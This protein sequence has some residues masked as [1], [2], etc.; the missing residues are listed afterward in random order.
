MKTQVHLPVHTAL[1]SDKRMELEPIELKYS[2][3]RIA[4]VVTFE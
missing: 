2:H 4:A 3:K 1:S